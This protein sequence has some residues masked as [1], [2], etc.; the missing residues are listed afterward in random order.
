MAPSE[1][2]GSTLHSTRWLRFSLR[3]TFV[4]VTL[5]CGWLAFLTLRARE[6][7]EA[8]E[9]VMQ[10][11][12]AVAY[13]FEIDADGNWKRN[14]QP[15]VPAW[16]RGRMGEDYFRCV[17][18]VN[19]NENADPADDDLRVFAKLRDVQQLS[20]SNCRKITDGGLIH[21]SG[22]VRLKVLVLDGTSIQGP[23]LCHLLP[24]RHLEGLT[25][26]ST[27]LSDDGLEKL[28]A[29]PNLKWLHVNDTNITDDGLK[30]LSTSRSLQSLQLVNTH[31]TDIGLKHLESL[32]GLKN[33]LLRGTKTTPGGRAALRKALPNCHVPD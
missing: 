12:G 19:F 17:A 13:G 1:Q 32:Q 5:Y 9:R 28:A 25:F 6:Q 27:P 29:L 14:A 31:V 2:P 24:L 11:H 18:I 33:V 16:I 7:H 22:L 21:L 4:L 26:S 10:L 20:F 8:V 15:L 30:R 23:G 3:T